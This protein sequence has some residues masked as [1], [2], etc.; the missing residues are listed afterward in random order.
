MS[1]VIHI[2]SAMFMPILFEV[3]K[4]K[5]TRIRNS[6]FIT[7]L[8]ERGDF[9]IVKIP[10]VYRTHYV[11]VSNCLFILDGSLQVAV[12]HGEQEFWNIPNVS[13]LSNW[14]LREYELAFWR[15]AITGNRGLAELMTMWLQSVRRHDELLTQR[16]L[17][18]RGVERL[19]HAVKPLLGGGPPSLERIH[20]YLDDLHD[21][22]LLDGPTKHGHLQAAVGGQLDLG[23]RKLRTEGP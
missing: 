19:K 4:F 15:W 23:G 3:G 16:C 22:C 17:L 9:R 14:E 2:L 12:R 1:F 18:I 13:S 7:D 10:N 5:H 20:A 21:G 6:R 11:Q 8:Y